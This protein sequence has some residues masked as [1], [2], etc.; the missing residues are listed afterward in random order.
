M[1]GDAPSKFSRTSFAAS[2]FAGLSVLGRSAE[3]RE[4]TLSNC[5]ILRQWQARWAIGGIRTMDSTVC[6]GSQRSPESS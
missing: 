3:S 1:W 5:G 4:T 2:T 6:T